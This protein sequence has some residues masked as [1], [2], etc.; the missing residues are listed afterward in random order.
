V[1]AVIERSSAALAGVLRA[2][3]LARPV[4][5]IHYTDASGGAMLALPALP[6]YVPTLKWMC[7][8][9]ASAVE[10]ADQ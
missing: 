1:S 9:G 6:T 4:D 2:M 10:S 7:P 3:L 5:S 8:C